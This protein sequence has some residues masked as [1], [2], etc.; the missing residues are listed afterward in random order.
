MARDDRLQQLTKRQRAEILGADEANLERI[1]AVYVQLYDR[2][3]GDI[4]ALTKA[5]SELDTKTRKAIERLPE[6]RRL[7]RHANDELER[8]TIYT[9]TTIE[10]AAVAAVGI[11]LAHSTEFIRLVNRGF[12]S[13]EARAMVPL[14]DYLRRDGPLYSRLA[15]LT[16]AT[17]DRVIDAILSGVSLGY[18]PQKIASQIQSAFGGGLTDALR[19]TR[20]VQLYAYRDSARANYMAS[21]GIVKGWI[22]YAELDANVCPSCIAQHGSIHPLDEKLD[23]HYNGRCA[24]IPYIEGLS[25]DVARGEEWF[26]GLDKVTQQKILGDAKHQ[27]LQDGKFTFDQLSRQT[28]NDVYGTMRTVP[29]LAELLGEE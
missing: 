20:T 11:G 27:G 6:Y 24:A 4:D 23:D 9:E 10:A 28:P 13:L 8:F 5:I 21:G 14:L 25:D 2:L 15:E 19:N 22:W 16:G 1:A 7:M 12:T 29:S 26:N 3:G 18:N 17:V